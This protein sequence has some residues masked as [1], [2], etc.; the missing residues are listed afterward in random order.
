MLTTL[1]GLLQGNA[2]DE[3]KQGLRRVQERRAN[4]FT[5]TQGSLKIQIVR[6]SCDFIYISIWDADLHDFDV[7]GARQC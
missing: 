1:D 5:Y 6:Q 3:L 4:S 2:P 7:R